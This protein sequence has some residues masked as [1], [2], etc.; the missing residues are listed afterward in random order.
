[1]D[2]QDY[3]TVDSE[4]KKVQHLQREERGVIQCLMRKGLS[5]RAIARESG[6]SPTTVGN[7]LKRGKPPR[8]SNI[9]QERPPT[10]PS[11]E[12][13]STRLIGSDLGST[14]R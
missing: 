14:I 12:K 3:I 6:C 2:C 9:G 8:K 7:E 10:P 5:N 13:R 4:R 1:M 11:V